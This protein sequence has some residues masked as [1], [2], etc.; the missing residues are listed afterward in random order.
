[1]WLSGNGLDKEKV[2]RMVDN[3][4]LQEERWRGERSNNDLEEEKGE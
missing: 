4:N 1:M 2:W 3:Y